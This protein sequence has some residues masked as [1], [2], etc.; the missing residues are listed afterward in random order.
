[1]A[2]LQT[3]CGLIMLGHIF[4][5]TRLNRAKQTGSLWEVHSSVPTCMLVILAH[6]LPVIVLLRMFGSYLKVIIIWEVAQSI[7]II[8]LY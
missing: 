5:Q 7:S 2:R 6:R 4:C 1:M 3:F 8:V